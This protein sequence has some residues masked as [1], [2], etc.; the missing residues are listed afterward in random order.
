MAAKN[1]LSINEIV[2]ELG[3]NSRIKRL[4]KLSNVD[5]GL[6]LDPK[7]VSPSAAV[8]VGGQNSLRGAPYVSNLKIVLLVATWYLCSTFANTASK[9]R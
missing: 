1:G 8:T 5:L 4:D 6:V 7:I 2:G 9:V 3:I